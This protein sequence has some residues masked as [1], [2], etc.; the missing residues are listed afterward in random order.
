MVDTRAGDACPLGLMRSNPKQQQ[1][2][3]SSRVSVV[4]ECVTN[5]GTDVS[6]DTA[7]VRDVHLSVCVSFTCCNRSAFSRQLKA[8]S[9]TQVQYL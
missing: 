5:E 2:G 4:S 3:V 1:Q 9:V 8:L 6:E 7:A